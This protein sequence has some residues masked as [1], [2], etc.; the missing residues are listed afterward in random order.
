[1]IDQVM[2]TDLIMKMDQSGLRHGN[3][4]HPSTPREWD[5]DKLEHGIKFSIFLR[6]LVC[7]GT[8]WRAFMIFILGLNFIT[9]MRVIRGFGL[10]KDN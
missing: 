10:N 5:E 1:M 2:A 3:E 6:V 8:D 9:W 7:S 4:Y